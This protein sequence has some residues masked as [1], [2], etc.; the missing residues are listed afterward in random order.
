MEKITERKTIF[1]GREKDYSLS[2]DY[3]VQQTEKRVLDFIDE[4]ACEDIDTTFEI[5]AGEDL[6]V[7]FTREDYNN[8]KCD[9]TLKQGASITKK[10]HLIENVSQ[11][12]KSENVEKSYNIVSKRLV[13][14]YF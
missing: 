13:R 7:K 8:D 10:L 2:L 1:E 14:L 5:Y 9:L 12:A 3:R 6:K 4:F 11:I